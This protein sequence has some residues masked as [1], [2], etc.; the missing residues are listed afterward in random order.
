[1]VTHAVTQLWDV[2]C[3]SI[4][5]HQQPKEKGNKMEKI[6][7]K[8]TIGVMLLVGCL[9]P[10]AAQAQHIHGHHE[11]GIIGVVDFG[12]SYGQPIGIWNI[13]VSNSVS[14]TLSA[15]VETDEY[16]IFAVDLKPGN[17]V[18]RASYIPPLGQQPTANFVIIG[19]ATSVRVVKNRFTFIVLPAT[20]FILP[21]RTPLSVRR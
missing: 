20:L 7:C 3:I 13:S 9:L 10:V 6:I 17:Y 16:G 14:G 19:P 4:M 18:L 11:S 5:E 1:M 21:I 12:Q 8:F 15:P 2:S